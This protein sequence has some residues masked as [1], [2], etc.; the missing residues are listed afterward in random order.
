[1]AT[2]GHLPAKAPGL[3]ALVAA[4]TLVL[5]GAAAQNASDNV[6]RSQVIDSGSAWRSKPGQPE[7]WRVQEPSPVVD[8]GRIVIE[9]AD[10]TAADVSREYNSLNRQGMRD[11]RPVPLVEWRF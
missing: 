6:F 4:M 9:P 7:R 1:M 11:P 3:L 2:A 8:G 10:R 5:A